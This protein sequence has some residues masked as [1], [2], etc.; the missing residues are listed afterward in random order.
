MTNDQITY[1][2][3]AVAAVGALVAF[4]S[5]ILVPAARSYSRGW[6]RVAAGFLSIYVLLAFLMVGVAGG[7]AVVWFWDR[8]A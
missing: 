3:A 1:L 2:V 7:T 4:T 5:L 8:F 6:E